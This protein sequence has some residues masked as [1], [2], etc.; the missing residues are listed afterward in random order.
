MYRNQMLS[1]LGMKSLYIFRYTFEECFMHSSILPV[2]GAHVM[3]HE[4]MSY[5]P[6]QE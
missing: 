5:I 6:N 1:H 4:Y 3:K 2:S